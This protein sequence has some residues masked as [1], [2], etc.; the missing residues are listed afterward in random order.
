MSLPQKLILTMPGILLGALI[1]IVS[2]SLAILGLLIVRRFISHAV[3]KQHNDV[4]GFIFATLGVIYA[5]LLAFTVIVVWENFGQAK[6]IVNKEAACLMDVF[7]DTATLPDPYRITVRKHLII[8]AEMV[9]N[10]EWKTMQH[11]EGSPRFIKVIQNLW[12]NLCSFKPRNFVDE[13]LF[14]EIMTKM[15]TVLSLRNE[16]L[17]QSRDGLNPLL[18]FVLILGGIITIIFTYFFGMENLQAQL[19]MTALLTAIV[20]LILFTIMS[21]DYPF[22]GDISISSEPFQYIL[23]VF[24]QVMG[25]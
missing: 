13:T 2:I 17:F 4:A 12:V 19:I 18:W 5:V 6:E 10:E 9:V 3:L 15:N 16:R 1:L 23:K 8:Y 11:G 14:R 20:A 21:L 7:R 22:T 25:I 24:R